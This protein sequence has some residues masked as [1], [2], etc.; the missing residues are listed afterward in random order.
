MLIHRI[1]RGAGAYHN[2]LRH[3]QPFA[4][5]AHKPRS[6]ERLRCVP[7]AAPFIFAPFKQMTSLLAG[8]CA[9]LRNET[10]SFV[11]RLRIR[12]Y[13]LVHFGFNKRARACVLFSGDIRGK[14]WCAPCREKLICVTGRAHKRFKSSP[15]LL[16]RTN[17]D[18]Q[19]GVHKALLL[20][21]APH[22]SC[23]CSHIFSLV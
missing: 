9:L 21:M 3:T 17:S 10:F 4:A 1:I 16:A 8:P 23:L 15:R 14:K 7:K 19:I 13:M 20:A 12:T 2:T 6:I 22:I 18:A 11:T 5:A